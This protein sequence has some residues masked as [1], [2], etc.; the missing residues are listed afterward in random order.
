MLDFLWSILAFIVAISV[1]VAVHEYGHFIVARKLG[2]KVLRFSI[3]FGRALLRWRSA[4]A[5]AVE[6]RLSAIPLGGYVKM[7]DEREGEV[8]PEDVPRAFNRRPVPARV[9]V[10]AA[11]PA[12]NFLFAIVAY[13][14]MFVSGIN[15]VTP[16]IG[17][18]RDGS[19]A[20]EAGL[21]SGDVIDSVGGA[22][23]ETLDQA[24]VAM[25]DELLG[26]GN[27]KLGVVDADGGHRDITLPVGDRVNELT[28]PDALFDK[29]GILIGLLRPPIAATVTEGMPAAQAGLE[30][31]DRIVE[32]DGHPI[33][34]FED[35]NTYIAPHPG[36]TVN[37]AVE[38]DGTRREF[39]VPIATEKDEEGRTVG[40]IG[41]QS[42]EYEGDTSALANRLYTV[43]RYGPIEGIGV[44]A[45]ETWQR[46][47]L[48]VKFLWRMVTG[49]V[50]IRNMSGP[51][52]IATYAGEFAQA[53]FNRFLQFLAMI[54]IS[55]GIV[56]LLPVPILDGGQIVMCLI[57]GIQRKPLSMRAAVIGQQIG[58][59][60]LIALMGLVF[61]NDITRLLGS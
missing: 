38:R 45:S 16:Y 55:L 36:E 21:K 50:S 10:L 39:A 53:G 48:S 58:L 37:V 12:F 13:W 22:R 2:F 15:D 28:E 35:L 26:D 43:R 33:Q 59:A 17:G 3:G 7:L 30:A 11:G 34:F 18:V 61:Y 49:D 14:L 4:D 29:L 32:I 47:A 57:E 60:M 27:I 5:D 8:A 25:F 44:A 24:A 40:R 46:S 1:L 31:G 20:A 56:N 42:P 6:Y 52:M 19:A 23:T 41:I 54:S 9:A 51:V